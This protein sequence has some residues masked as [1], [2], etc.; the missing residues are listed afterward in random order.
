MKK[1]KLQSPSHSCDFGKKLAECFRAQEPFAAPAVKYSSHTLLRLNSTAITSTSW[2]WSY[3]ILFN[4]N[5]R[6]HQYIILYSTPTTAINLLRNAYTRAHGDPI[7]RHLG[8]LLRVVVWSGCVTAHGTL[9]YSRINS[10]GF[11]GISVCL[12]RIKSSWLLKHVSAQRPQFRFVQVR[13]LSASCLFLLQD[14]INCSYISNWL[15]RL[16]AQKSFPKSRRDSSK[17]LHCLLVSSGRWL[18]K[19]ISREISCHHCP[20]VVFVLHWSLQCL[21]LVRRSFPPTLK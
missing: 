17:V 13:L 15:T 6:N 12:M 21:S 10:E 11:R 7:S 20:P 3:Y 4:S 8:E 14:S 16:S 9:Y 19:H 1:R 18:T 2:W 5:D